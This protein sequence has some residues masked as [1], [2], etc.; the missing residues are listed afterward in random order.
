MTP[1]SAVSTFRYSSPI[2]SYHLG[3][4]SLVEN[5]KD[6]SQPVILILDGI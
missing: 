4:S 1:T 2:L 3:D 6:R 5:L